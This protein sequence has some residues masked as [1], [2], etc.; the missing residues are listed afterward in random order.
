MDITSDHG[1]NSWKFYDDTMMG[2]WWKRCDGRTDGQTDRQ[3]DGR[4]DWTS[5]IAA[6]SQLKM[7][8]VEVANVKFRRRR[9]KSHFTARIWAY[10]EILWGMK[11]VNSSHK[12]TDSLRY[13]KQTWWK[14]E[15]QFDGPCVGV[16]LTWATSLYSSSLATFEVTQC[17]PTVTVNCLKYSKRHPVMSLIKYNL[18]DSILQVIWNMADMFIQLY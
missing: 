3:T 12:G 7:A 13:L 1:N 11:H 8:I 15:L 4:T 9:W 2:T 16:Y 14:A 6:W 10:E 18:L 5:H 17:S